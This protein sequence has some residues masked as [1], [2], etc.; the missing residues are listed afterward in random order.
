MILIDI[1]GEKNKDKL[2][3]WKTIDIRTSADYVLDLNNF[4]KFP[5]DNVDAYYTSHTLEHL[6]A[7]AIKRVLAECYRTLKRGGRIRAVVPDI[8]VGIGWYLSNPNKLTSKEAPTKPNEYPDTALG[9][10]MSWFYTPDKVLTGGHKMAFNF[11]LLAF[12]LM[13]AGFVNIKKMFYNECSKIFTG[14]DIERY[15]EFSLYVEATK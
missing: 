13:G 14:K 6:S 2:G 5:I 12:Y 15:K 7:R 3:T 9:Y 8:D 11:K 4:T 10:L 1:G